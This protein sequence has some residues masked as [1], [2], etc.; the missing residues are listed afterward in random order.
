LVCQSKC[1][2]PISKTKLIIKDCHEALKLIAF[3]KIAV[4]DI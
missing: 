3:K 4:V 1:N 2:V